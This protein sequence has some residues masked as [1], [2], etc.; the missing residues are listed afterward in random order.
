[1]LGV[2][3]K[4]KRSEVVVVFVVAIWNVLRPIAHL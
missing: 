3:V 4:S 1:M 2:V